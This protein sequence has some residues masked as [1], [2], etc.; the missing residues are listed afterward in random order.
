MEDMYQA[1]SLAWSCNGATL[2]VA[3]GKTN[4]Q[5]WCEHHSAISTWGI[6]RREFDPKKPN[7]TIELQNCVTTIEF[8]PSDPVILAGGTMNGEIFLWNIDS[9]RKGEDPMICKSDVDEY[10]H[11]EAVTKLIW[12]KYESMTSLAF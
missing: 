6:F 4:H 5:T 9:E 7:M 8:H 12:I 2:A 3:Y 10:Y 1:V 11:R